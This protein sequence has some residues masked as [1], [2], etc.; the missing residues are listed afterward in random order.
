ME[1]DESRGS[2]VFFQRNDVK[3]VYIITAHIPLMRTWTFGHTRGKLGN[4]SM[5]W[6]TR[7]LDNSEAVGVLILTIWSWKCVAEHPPHNE[8]FTNTPVK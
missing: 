2:A 8:P 1:E 6:V 4:V 7:Y 3:V 5:N